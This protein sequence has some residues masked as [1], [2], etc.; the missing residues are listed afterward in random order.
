MSAPRYA[1]IPRAQAR[2]H[3]TPWDELPLCDLPRLGVAA[4][5]LVC[6]GWLYP[7]KTPEQV[8]RWHGEC[9]HTAILPV[10]PLIAASKWAKIGR[11][12]QVFFCS[13]CGTYSPALVPLRRLAE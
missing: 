10:E 6:Q 3:E 2:L 7:G 5:K 9:R 13:R 12:R 1:R 8:P 11:M 4:I